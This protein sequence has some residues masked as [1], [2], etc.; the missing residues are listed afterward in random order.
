MDQEPY[1]YEPLYKT[2]PSIRLMTILPPNEDGELCLDLEVM[3][4]AAAADDYA[5]VSYAWGPGSAEHRIWIGDKL[6]LLRSSIWR[7]LQHCCKTEVYGKAKLWIDSI[8]ID[9]DNVLRR[10]PRYSS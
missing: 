9:Q 7:F 8:C 10:I 5:A 3:S 6:L 1:R 2:T 4:L